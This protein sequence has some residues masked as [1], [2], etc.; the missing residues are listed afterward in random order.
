MYRAFIYGLV[1]S[2]WIALSAH[3]QEAWPIKDDNICEFVSNHKNDNSIYTFPASDEFTSIVDKIT[4]SLGLTPNFELRQ[5]NVL[6]AAAVTNENKRY[7][8]YSTD[9]MNSIR[10]SSSNDLSKWM[11]LAH[12]I[13]HH[14]NGHT[15]DDIGSRPE[16]ELAADMFAG[17]VIK[18]MGGSLTAA[19]EVYR[20]MPEADSDTHPGRRARIEAVI[21]GFNSVKSKEPVAPTNLPAGDR[22]DGLILTADQKVYSALT[23]E[24]VGSFNSYGDAFDMN[25]KLL[26]K[27]IFSDYLLG[28]M[29]DRMAL[30]I[31]GGMSSGQRKIQS[32][33]REYRWVNGGRCQNGVCYNDNSNR[34]R[35]GPD[36][37]EIKP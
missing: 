6:N 30:D 10:S 9:F 7:I 17:S 8:L 34:V 11:I 37:K 2:F 25:K 32:N 5:A 14:L 23:G 21:R 1:L 35:I 18:R 4:L 29:R 22:V 20:A 12:E 24:Q 26:S 13:G 36:G 19:L 31:M 28:K 3:A 27:G 15:L 16:K 33:P